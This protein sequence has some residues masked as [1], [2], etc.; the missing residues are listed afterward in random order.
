M[1]EYQEL[2]IDK[3]NIIQKNKHLVFI[4][5]LI[6]ELFL[7]RLYFPCQRKKP[8]SRKQTFSS[9]LYN[10]LFPSFMHRYINRIMIE[11]ITEK[12]LKRMVA[13]ITRFNDEKILEQLMK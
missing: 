10:I 4:Q 3:P 5:G 1:S 7:I 12:H 6:A 11:R 8:T 9:K 2:F 13:D